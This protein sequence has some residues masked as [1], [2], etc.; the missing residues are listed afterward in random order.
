[1]FFLIIRLDVVIRH[2]L[3]HDAHD[4]LIARV[5]QETN[6]RFYN[7][8][9]SFCIKPDCTTAIHI[10]SDRELCFIAIIPW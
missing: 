8:V 4:F 1:M 6:R 7:T 5:L 9:A 2:K 10:P 3:P